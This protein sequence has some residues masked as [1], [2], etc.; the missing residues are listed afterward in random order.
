M[1]L[2]AKIHSRAI[3]LLARGFDSHKVGLPEWLKNAR[4]A[5]WRARAGIEQ[6]PVVVNLQDDCNHPYLECTDFAGITG[7]AIAD[8]Y[9]Q[10][11]NRDAAISGLALKLT[12][13]LF[14]GGQGGGPI[15]PLE[16]TSF[17]QCAQ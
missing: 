3:D 4:E 12:R 9:L 1:E 5:Y 17:T 6:R 13:W 7:D 8:N 15:E 2:E 16:T 10:W 11:A 14:N